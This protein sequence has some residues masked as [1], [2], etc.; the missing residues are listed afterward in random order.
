MTKP[1]S[2]LTFWGAIASLLAIPLTIL[3]FFAEC[4]SERAR[5]PTT[6]TQQ[7]VKES[8]EPV[9]KTGTDNSGQVAST[10]RP[11]REN[12]AYESEEGT[13]TITPSKPVAEYEYKAPVFIGNSLYKRS[14]RIEIVGSERIGD[15]KLKFDLLVRS[16]L[17]RIIRMRLEEPEQMAYIVD[18][19]G[20]RYFFVEQENLTGEFPS[21]VD[22]RGSITM[23]A[24]PEATKLITVVFRYR[25]GSGRPDEVI[26]RN[27]DLDKMKLVQ[28]E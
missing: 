1:F 2:R 18:S 6:T 22:V 3:L 20:V 25:V 9:I 16:Q 23:L 28:P 5:Q 7:D 15:S 8:A 19:Q 12:Q 21:G 17:D 11:S 10:E 27:L 24:P 13:K 4:S 14:Y 26:F